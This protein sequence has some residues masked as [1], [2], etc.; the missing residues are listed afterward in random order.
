MRYY[1]I[2][3]NKEIAKYEQHIDLI[4]K[5]IQHKNRI[6]EQEF[7]NEYENR[8]SLML[9][10]NQFYNIYKNLSPF[11]SETTFITILNMLK[12]INVY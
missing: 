8:I 11:L 12:T 2:K 3:D 5:L 7:N 1:F 4:N 10:E 9:Y 6:L